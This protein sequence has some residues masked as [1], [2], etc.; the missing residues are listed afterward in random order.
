MGERY[1]TGKN[2]GFP[3]LDIL[4]YLKNTQKNP[5]FGNP[6]QGILNQVPKLGF[7]SLSQIWD[8]CGY[9]LNTQKYPKLGIRY[10]FLWS[11]TTTWYGDD[12][13]FCGF[14]GQWR[15]ALQSQHP[16]KDA[17]YLWT[18]MRWLC[19]RCVQDL[20]CAG[21][22]IVLCA[23]KMVSSWL[24]MFT[25]GTRR[26]KSCTVHGIGVNRWSPDVLAV[27]RYHILASA[28][29]FYN[30]FSVCK[31]CH[32]FQARNLSFLLVVFDNLMFQHKKYYYL[33]FCSF[34]PLGK[35]SLYR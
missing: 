8:F 16:V 27:K 15:Q 33:A 24:I 5:K 20:R 25:A 29:M 19:S 9:S 11:E 21:M 26:N 17:A 6:N 30:F 28:C 2:N 3:I 14:Q 13:I 35:N 23:A 31:F 4:G 34:Y 7:V 18:L 10:F 22:C 32:S 1:L 12:L